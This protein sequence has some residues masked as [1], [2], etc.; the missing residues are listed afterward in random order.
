MVEIAQPDAQMVKQLSA[1]LVEDLRARGRLTTREWEQALY[2]VPRYR[3]VPATAWVVANHAGAPTGLIDASKDRDGWLEAIYSDTSV[4]LQEDDGAGDPTAGTGN[5]T[6]SVSAPGIVVP[7]LELLEPQPGDRV[8]DV[9]TGSGWTAALLSWR[10]GQDGVTSI[11]V[12]PEVAG[13][14]EANLRAAGFAPHL[15]VGDGLKGCP[16]R[17][18]FDHV[19]VTA[20]ASRIPI[21]WIEQTRPGGTIV[22]PWHVGGRVGHMVRLTV[23]GESTAVGSFHGPASYMMV[24]S[25]RY[26]TTWNAHHDGEAD[27]TTTR[28]DPRRVIEADAGASLMSAALAPRIGWHAKTGPT[29]TSLMLFELDDQNGSWAACY[30]QPGRDD[31]EVLQYGERQLWDE[32]ADA[33]L[34]WLALGSPGAERFGLTVNPDGVHVWLDHP[35]G[36]SWSLPT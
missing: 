24:R 7:F 9:G 4:I 15:L 5:F 29:G 12:D 26:N 35:G 10:A 36:P 23:T 1:R 28:I 14:A 11:E 34:Q 16:D 18:P 27:R 32:V 33:Y 30:R 13:Q 20:G 17:A 31:N 22:L 21:A 8:L 19:H 3:F 2:A 25:Q 6:S